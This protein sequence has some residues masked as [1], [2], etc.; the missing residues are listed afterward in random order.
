MTLIPEKC[1]ESNDKR[2]ICIVEENGKKFELKNDSQFHIRKVKVNFCLAQ[3]TNEKRCDYLISID[4]ID[5]PI[6][7]F[8]ELKGGDLIQAVKQLY[9]SIIFLKDEFKSYILHARIIGSRDVPQ[10]ISTPSYRKLA[11]IIEP[12]LGS[13][14]RG[15]NNIMSET[16]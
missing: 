11:R 5:R 7:F 15:T 13:I 6:V 9:D 8:I 10:F 1:I 14:K 4:E 16:I 12:S 2:K 3:R